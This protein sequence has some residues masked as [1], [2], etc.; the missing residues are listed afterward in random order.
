MSQWRRSRGIFDP[1]REANKPNRWGY[2]SARHT[3]NLL[4]LPARQWLD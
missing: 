1:N 2:I 4:K 3:K